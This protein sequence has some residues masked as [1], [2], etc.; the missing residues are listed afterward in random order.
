MAANSPT[1]LAVLSDRCAEGGR[2]ACLLKLTPPPG[3][4]LRAIAL[5]RSDENLF[6]PEG[7]YT[8]KGGE[9]I[10]FPGD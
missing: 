7:G 10:Y 8:N 4:L 9:L 6:L 1:W 3:K 2:I 5:A